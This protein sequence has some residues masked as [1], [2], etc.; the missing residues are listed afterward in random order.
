MSGLQVHKQLAVLRDIGDM[1]STDYNKEGQRSV[2]ARQDGHTVHPG[3]RARFRTPGSTERVL[4]TTAA[5]R[6]PKE[7]TKR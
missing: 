3:V 6:N 1:F 2:T 4:R 5:L 7:D